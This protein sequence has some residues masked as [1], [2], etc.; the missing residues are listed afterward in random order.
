MISIVS[1]YLHA[2]LALPPTLTDS[3]IVVVPP[4]DRVAP[5]AT[6]ILLAAAQAAEGRFCTESQATQQAIIMHQ[7]QLES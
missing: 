3:L 5:L 4:S 7:S 2:C 1:T 6:I